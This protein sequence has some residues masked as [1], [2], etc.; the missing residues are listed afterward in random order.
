MRGAVNGFPNFNGCQVKAHWW[1]TGDVFTYTSTYTTCSSF[2]SQGGVYAWN[3]TSAPK[4][5]GVGTQVCGTFI[6]R[7]SGTGQYWGPAQAVCVTA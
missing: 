6:F 5:V 3:Y 7:N 4:N 2:V 1:T